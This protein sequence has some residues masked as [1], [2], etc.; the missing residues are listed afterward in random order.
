MKDE[1]SFCVCTY[2][3]F[4]TLHDCL[5]SI[6]EVS[7]GSRLIVVDHGSRDGTLE[8]AST[9]SAEIHSENKGLGFARQLCFDLVNTKFIVFVDSDVELVR[10][11]FLSIS[12][13]VLVNEKY[14]AVVGMSLGHRLSYGLPA[15][16][17]A[18]RKRDFDGKIIPDYIDARETYFVQRRLDE[19]GLKTFYVP[20]AMVHRSQ[21]RRAKPEW[22]GANTRILPSPMLKE[23]A[24]SLKVIVLMG[25]NSHRVKNM[26]YVPIFY[27]KFL[28][29]FTNPKPWLRLKRE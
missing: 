9:F 20:D 7:N 18:L 1:F 4:K 26:A 6:R 25:L 10:D 23:L 12:T 11:D 14:G 5:R 16:L 13:R 21:F 22:E 2:N 27:L 24:F 17:L 19:R 29:G 28:N 8:M 3:S 15:G